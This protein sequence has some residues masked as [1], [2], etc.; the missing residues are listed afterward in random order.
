MELADSD[1]A[2]LDFEAAAPRNIGIKEEKIRAQLGLTP[3]RYYHR[4]NMLIDAPAASREYPQLVAR[5][6][7]L[8]QLRADQRDGAA[9]KVG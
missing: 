7:R 8:R 9:G 5:L 1:R 2:I 4:L 3:I 6:Q